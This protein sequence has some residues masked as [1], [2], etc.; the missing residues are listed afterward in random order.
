[1]VNNDE[2]NRLRTTF[3]NLDKDGDGKLSREEL[4]N[5]YAKMIGREDAEAEVDRIMT[6][7][8]ITNTGFIDYSE[9][10]VASMNRHQL[11]SKENL[12]ATFSAFDASGKG[13]ISAADIRALIG[14]EAAQ[15]QVWHDLLADIEAR[16]E[17]DLATFKTSMTNMF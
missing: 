2:T 9:F 17:I 12:E 4:L 3:R 14:E 15:E 16:G 13:V 8:D 7:M 6:K 5:G 10:I 11:L 1:L